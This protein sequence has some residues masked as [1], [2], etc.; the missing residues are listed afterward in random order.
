MN[1]GSRNKCSPNLHHVC[2]GVWEQL[3]SQQMTESLDDGLGLEFLHCFAI[4]PYL[5]YLVAIMHRQMYQN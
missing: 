1:Q 5:F 3:H 2:G 4:L